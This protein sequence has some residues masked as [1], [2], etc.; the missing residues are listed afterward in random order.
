MKKKIRLSRQMLILAALALCLIILGCVIFLASRWTEEAGIQPDSTDASSTLSDYE[1]ETTE[2]TEETVNYSVT[3]DP[4]AFTEPEEAHLETMPDLSARQKSVIVPEGPDAGASYFDDAVFI[5]DSRTEGFRMH[6]GISA[7]KADFLTKVGMSVDW[8]CSENENRWL[9]F[10][11]EDQKMSVITALGRKQYK[12]IYISLGINETGWMTDEEFTSLYRN[13]LER[14]R[15]IQ[16]DAEIYLQGIIHV[17]QAR[18]DDGVNTNAR[19]NEMNC[20]IMDLAAE[21]GAHYLDLN[22]VMTNEN[23]HLFAYG[24]AKDGVHMT[25]SFYE[26]WYLY[27]RHHT[28]ERS[29]S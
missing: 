23:G 5:G 10:P 3:P 14:I 12:K 24:A 27:L 2:P 29:K 18:S 6:S 17:T 19:V 4:T 8:V 11:G 7:T 20:L 21:T 28:A 25:K 1:E 22:E 15:Q 13:F 9:E 16:P 26:V